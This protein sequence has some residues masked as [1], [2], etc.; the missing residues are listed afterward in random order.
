M[1]QAATAAQDEVGEG[2]DVKRRPR[3]S[4]VCKAFSMCAAVVFFGSL[5]NATSIPLQKLLTIAG[6]GPRISKARPSI[7]WR[8]SAIARAFDC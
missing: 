4:R 2:E 5:P 6:R 7:V 8:P 1:A 3:E